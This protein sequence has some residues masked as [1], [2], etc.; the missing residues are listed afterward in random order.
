M[1]GLGRTGPD[2]TGPA[3]PARPAR[4]ASLGRQIGNIVFD[5]AAPIALYYGLRAAGLSSL[6]ALAIGAGIPAARR[7]PKSVLTSS[8]R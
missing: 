5:I 8:T 1:T 4:P 3:R 6:A 7:L 2:R